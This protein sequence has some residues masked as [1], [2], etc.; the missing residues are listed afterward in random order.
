VIAADYH[1]QR[2]GGKNLAHAKGDV[3]VAAH[4]LGMDDVGIADIDDPYRSQ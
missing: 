4:R 1:R 3:G 2:A